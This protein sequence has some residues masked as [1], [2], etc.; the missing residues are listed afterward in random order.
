M[1]TEETSGG[2]GGKRGDSTQH[3]ARGTTG[4]GHTG[5]VGAQAGPLAAPVGEHGTP[6]AMQYAVKPKRA[7]TINSMS[8][9]RMRDVCI[10][11]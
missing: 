5:T 11:V 10:L 6:W 2:A 9:E 1:I 8:E 7:N 3:G 4:G